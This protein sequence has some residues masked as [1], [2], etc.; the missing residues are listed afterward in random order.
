MIA[1]R[2][3]YILDPIS[4][5]IFG[6][7]QWFADILCDKLV[8]SIQYFVTSI[9]NPSYLS[10]SNNVDYIIG[11]FSIFQNRFGFG[12]NF[13]AYRTH[14]LFLYFVIHF[15]RLTNQRCRNYWSRCYR[16]R[17]FVD[18]KLPRMRRTSKI[19]YLQFGD[20]EVFNFVTYILSYIYNKYIW[21]KISRC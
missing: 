5:D 21:I 15:N 19:K 8:F 11:M 12:F 13:T 3:R 1:S 9:F 10:K 7:P 2:C 16:T 20:D 4:Y 14:M 18:S 6:L 17:S